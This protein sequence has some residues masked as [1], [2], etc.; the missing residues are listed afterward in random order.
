M[1]FFLADILISKDKD[2]D[3]NIKKQILIKGLDL[4][5]KELKTSKTNNSC[6]TVSLRFINIRNM[7][8]L[9]Y[10]FSGSNKETNVLSFLPD[11][12]ETDEN[13]NSVGD[14]AI[15]VDVLKKEA[16]EQN[17]DF[18]DHLLH[19]FVHGIL[20]LLGYKHDSDREALKMEQI[21]KS[22]LSKLGIEDP[23]LIEL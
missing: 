3:L 23:Y 13:N 17:K 14:I 1:N 15:C 19:L 2:V 20:H 11:P 4:I 12:N 10:S 21:E 18:L 16:K 6:L 9:N 7:K 22:I 8:K 5:N